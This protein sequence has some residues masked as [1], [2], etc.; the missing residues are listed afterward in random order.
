MRGWSAYFSYG[1]RLMAYR[2]VDN[3]AYDGLPLP[4]SAA[5]GA[6]GWHPQVLRM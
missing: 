3:N 1:M 6:T 2:A 4:Q 5:Q